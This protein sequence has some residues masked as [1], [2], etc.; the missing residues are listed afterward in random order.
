M[1]KNKKK[2]DFVDDGRVIA[3][4]DI[5]GM[6]HRRK[7]DANRQR[8]YDLDKKEKKQLILASYKAFLPVLLCGLGGMLLAMF[9]IMWWLK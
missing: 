8:S 1:K 4:M 9:L 5:D 7:E 3:N 2:D 6:P